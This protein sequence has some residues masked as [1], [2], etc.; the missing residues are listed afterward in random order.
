[1]RHIRE[2]LQGLSRG[3]VVAGVLLSPW[4]FA[5]AEPW[6]YLLV[7]L[8]VGV[9]VAAWLLSLLYDPETH[10]R[11]PGLTLALV[12]LS[13]LVFL[14][15]IPLPASVVR[16]LS[17]LS[18]HAQEAR[19]QA[20]RETAATEFLPAGVKESPGWAALS[21]SPRATRRSFY[22]FAAYV[23]A[24]LVLANTITERAHLRQAASAI[25]ISS[26]VM[27]VFALVQKFSGTQDI[28]WFHTP[29]FGGSIFGPFTNRNHYAAHMSMAFSLSLGLLLALSRVPE[30]RALRTWRERL[31]W[32]STGKASRITLTGFAAALMGASVCVTLSRGGITSLA[33]ALG[34]IGVLVALRSTVPNRGRVVATVALLVVVAVVWLGWQ[35]VVERLGTLAEVAR[36]PM[37]DSR[38]A[39]TRDT[40]RIFAAAP[41]FGCGFGSFQYVF[42]R[43]ESP[44][45]QFGRWLHAHNDWVQLLAEGGIVG[46]FLVL[47]SALL[48]VRTVIGEFSKASAEGRLF[49]VGP[50]VGL[51]AIALHSFVDYSLHKPANAWLLAALCGMVVGA[52]HLRNDGKGTKLRR[53]RSHGFKQTSGKRAEL[54]TANTAQC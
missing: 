33:A 7:S 42:P 46:A 34:V 44:G 30:F 38:Y 45:I 18:A 23:G 28:Y 6:A 15:T 53:R 50:A 2:K 22:L 51:A 36:D 26:F 9:G 54:A 48:F 29:R 32:L 1:M 12:V 5:S 17:P 24:F 43:F 4:L 20:F 21:A 27:A 13:A 8:L 16:V 39:A 25:V 35:P 52:V 31:A 10:L 14:Q 37:F 49:A 19:V 11:A 40:L 3:A 41:A 47:L